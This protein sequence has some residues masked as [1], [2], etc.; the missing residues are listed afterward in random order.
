MGILWEIGV[1]MVFGGARFN[2]IVEEGMR[3]LNIGEEGIWK[4]GMWTLI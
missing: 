2:M 4:E 1:L 3:T